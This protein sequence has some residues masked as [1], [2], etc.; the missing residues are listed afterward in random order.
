MEPFLFKKKNM[1]TFHGMDNDPIPI[2]HPNTC[3][4]DYVK[5]KNI[6][7]ENTLVTIFEDG[8]F[9]KP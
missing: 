3:H 6:Q 4:V 8:V 2:F 1:D 5:L 9:K 7:V